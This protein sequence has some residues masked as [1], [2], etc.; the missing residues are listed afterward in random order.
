MKLLYGTGNQA[1]LSV[2]RSRLEKFGIE[3]IGL[4]DLKKVGKEIPKVEENGNFLLENAKVK[5]LGQ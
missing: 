5:A 3:L 1:K 2:M 4:E